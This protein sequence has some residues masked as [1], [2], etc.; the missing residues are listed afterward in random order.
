MEE[1]S[2]SLPILWA[3]PSTDA[4]QT[5]DACELLHLIFNGN[6]TLPK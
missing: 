2:K 3:S 4:E 5:T 6:F 1:D